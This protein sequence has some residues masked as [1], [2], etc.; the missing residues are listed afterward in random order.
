MEQLMAPERIYM[1]NIFDILCGKHIEWLRLPRETRE[2]YLRRME[3]S[4]FE[5]TIN[6]CILDGVDRLFTNIKFVQR[7][8]VNCSRVISNL[9]SDPSVGDTDVVA[10]IISGEIDTYYIAHMT[11]M[12]LYPEASSNERREIEIRKTQKITSKVSRAHT[13]KKCGG[14]ETIPIEYQARASDE[15]SSFSIKCVNCDYVWRR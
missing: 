11:S 2:T 15:G 6:S 8:S 13:C 12:E 3:R 14:N 5:I 10:R 1:K 7:Y 9:G 4:C